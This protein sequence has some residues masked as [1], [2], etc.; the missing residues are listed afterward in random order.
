M[1]KGAFYMMI[2][3]DFE[4]FPT[5]STSLDFMR[6]L[7][8][9]QNVYIFPGEPFYYPGFFRIVLTAPEDTLVEA[10]ERIKEFCAKHYQNKSLL[11][12]KQEIID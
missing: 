10:C 9:E 6:Q 3:I 11:N 7:K 12:G 5:I 4:K 1:P 8:E 2:G